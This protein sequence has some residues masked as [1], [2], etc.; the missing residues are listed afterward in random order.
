M[1]TITVYVFHPDRGERDDEVSEY[2]QNELSRFVHENQ[3]MEF[4]FDCTSAWRRRF[5]QSDESD[6]THFLLLER[7][8]GVVGSMFDEPGDS[9]VLASLNGSD[10]AGFFVRDPHSGQPT[11]VWQLLNPLGRFDRIRLD[12]KSGGRPLCLKPLRTKSGRAVQSCLVS[13]LDRKEMPAPDAYVYGGEW[14]AESWL[15]P[16]TGEQCGWIDDRLRNTSLE[17]VLWEEIEKFSP[18]T[19]V[20]AVTCHC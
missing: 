17:E 20:T 16:I 10:V 12:G 18:N 6:F 3:D 15:N 5:C 11:K 9:T 2:V 4:W 19:R 14:I 7:F 13:H 1:S 8:Q